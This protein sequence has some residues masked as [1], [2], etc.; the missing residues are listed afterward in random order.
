[1]ASGLGFGGYRISTGVA[2]HRVALEEGLR[3]GVNLIDTSAN[4]ADGG[5]ERLIGEV[6]GA[7]ME[8]GAI[9]RDETVVVSKGGYIQG[10]NMEHARAQRESGE[11]FPD[12]VELGR[13]LWHSISPEFL[14]DQ[15]ARSR[16][17]LGLQQID[18]Y[19]L[20]N[21]EYYLTWAERQELPA[22]VARAEYERRLGAAFDHLEREVIDGRIGWYGVSSN[23]FPAPRGAYN[24]THLDRLV[25]IAE[26]I[27]PDHHF[28][29]VQFPANLLERG[30]V[31]EPHDS[32]GRTLVEVAQR[33]GLGTLANR[34]LNAIVN[35]ELMRLAD[36]PAA[37][38]EESDVIEKMVEELEGEERRFVLEELERFAD[39]PEGKRAL[40]EFLSVGSTMER[41]RDT[42]GSIEQYNDVLS[43]HFAPRL[44]WTARYFSERGTEDLAEWYAGYLERARQLLD[45]VGAGYAGAAQK[46]SDALRE[47]ID[48]AME[49]QNE[50]SLSQLA[51][52]LLWGAG[53]DA[54]LVGMRRPSYV[55][56]MLG[57]LQSG[58]LGTV[59]TWRG[60]APRLL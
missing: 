46:R 35:N 25:A 27:R 56:D 39:D 21:P 14:H 42:F 38:Q 40:R 7:L 53:V 48:A 13:D 29:V 41:Y 33:A 26:A 17:R 8:E 12:V 43:H 16:A 54:V 2:E 49:T 37:A 36:F 15:I 30:F 31:A 1:M 4:Y 44:A 6:L 20:H 34:P 45:A 3:S 59:E 24:A 18:L 52:R 32:T 5:S 10:G 57:A 28:S 58:P 22:E 11:G 60:L 55:E 19:L 50:G 9:R 23:T 51:V 47:L